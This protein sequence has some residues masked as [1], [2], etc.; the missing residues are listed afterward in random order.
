MHKAKCKKK[1]FFSHYTLS[2]FKQILVAYFIAHL[3]SQLAVDS[4]AEA[5]RSPRSAL[6]DR[7]NVQVKGQCPG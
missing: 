5:I 3:L 2:I 1:T 4:Q 7:V 6:T